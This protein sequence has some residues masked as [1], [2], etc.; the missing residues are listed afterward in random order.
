MKQTMKAMLYLGPGKLELREVALPQPQKGEVL[1]KVRA[2]T[3][4]GTDVKTYLRGHPKIT[5]PCLFGHELAGEIVAVGEG[6]ENFQ[7]GMRVVCHNTAPCGS[8]YYCK[9]GY[10]NLCQK[11]IYNFGSYAEYNCV[12]A[13][14]VSVNMFEIPESLS[15]A[16]A[17]I[18]EPLASVVHGQKKVGITLGET[19]VIIGAGPIGLMHLMLSKINGAK[20]V[21]VVDV[22]SNRL[23][24]AKEFGADEI[25]NAKQQ[26]P[27]EII[28]MQTDGRG[29]DVCIE[30]VGQKQT[31]LQAVQMTRPG[32]RVLWFGGLPAGT[33]LE[34]NAD[35]LH[36]SEITLFGSYHA[37]P[38]DVQTA[39]DLIA[40]RA[41]DVSSLVSV[42]LPLD[43]LDKALQMMMN[44]EVVKAAITP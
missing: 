30:C 42:E 12:P 31:W 44:G 17:A 39:F 20:S 37:T 13:P 14:I 9:H 7:V 1:V 2:A 10:H 41:L 32:G 25:I 36:Y 40:S 18:L 43:Q 24:I 19:V 4:C 16:E 28:K 23:Q 33:Q 34:L 38:Y 5:P 8:C 6:V 21:I 29:A 22:Q 15:F 11:L 3:T 26:D 35:Y 27:L